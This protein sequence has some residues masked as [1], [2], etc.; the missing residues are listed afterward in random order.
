[1]KC[2]ICKKNINETFL[3]KLIGTYVKDKQGKKHV[4]CSECQGKLRNKDELLTKL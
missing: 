1:M 2:D 3:R 4:V